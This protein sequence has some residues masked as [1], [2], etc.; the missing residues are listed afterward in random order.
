MMNKS[1][2][3]YMQIALEEARQTKIDVPVGAV[4]IDDEGKVISKAFNTKEKNHSV[5][6]HAEI[7]SLLEAST[8]LGDW[9]LNNTTLF[10]TLE[11]CPMCA[12][13]ILNSRV[14]TVVFGAFD[15]KYGAFGST[16]D[17][18]NMIDNKTQ[19]I[20]GILENECKEL[21]QVFFDEQRLK[22]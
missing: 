10:V 3:Y 8:K 9:R 15:T 11:P 7:N 2:E 12:T 5:I 18:R 14:S 20:S 22:R 1:Y 21:I 6:E 4:L 13:A 16:I 17:L 19:V